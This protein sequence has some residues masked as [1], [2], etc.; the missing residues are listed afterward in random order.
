M[1]IYLIFKLSF[2][3]F[4]IFTQQTE[5]NKTVF[6]GREE[7][8]KCSLI[9]TFVC[10]YHRLNIVAFYFLQKLFK[11]TQLER[12][13]KIALKEIIFYFRKILQLSRKNS[14][15]SPVGP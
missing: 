12:A 9:G 7:Y 6:R 13:K 1:R 10:M 3:A 2:F 4:L 15:N 11:L 8:A 14:S 5:H